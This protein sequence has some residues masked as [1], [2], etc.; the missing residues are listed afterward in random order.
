MMHRFRCPKCKRVYEREA[1]GNTKRIKSYCGRM[2]VEV[3][4]VR[5]VYR[6]VK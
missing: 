4:L 1:H 2:G 3:E 5:V 6:R